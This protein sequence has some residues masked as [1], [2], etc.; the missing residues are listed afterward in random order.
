M[1]VRPEMVNGFG[2]VARRHRVLARRQR[3]GVRV[4]HAGQ[5]H[6]GDRELDHVSEGRSTSATCSPP[7]P[8][9]ESA[10]NRLGVLSRDRA[11]SEGRIVVSTFRGTVYKTT[12]EHRSMSDAYIVDGVRTADRQ[13]RR[14]AERR[15]AD[16]LAAHA[17]AR[18]DAPP[19]VA[20]S[21]G[22]RRRRA[23]LRQSG[24]RGQSQRRAHGAAARRAAG[25]GAGRDGE[26]AVR[27]G[28]ERGGDGGARREARRRRLLH[29]RRR[30]EHDARAVRDVE[31]EQAVRARH[32]AVRHEPRLALRESRG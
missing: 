5:R 1:T 20:R 10:T 23:R 29:R 12:S 16:D 2:V 19:S 15:A 18:A 9:E 4:Q 32:R 7:S 30:R 11:Q 21:G 3:A 14:R 17:I 6:G 26:S 27:V 24:G 13:H 22:D 8:S 25:L 31:G 28:H